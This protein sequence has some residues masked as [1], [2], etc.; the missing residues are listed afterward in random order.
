MH[1]AEMDVTEMTSGY[2]S[3]QLSELLATVV[4]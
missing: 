2:D 1:L 4:A 3:I